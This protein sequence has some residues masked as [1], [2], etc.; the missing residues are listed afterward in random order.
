MSIITING[1][2]RLVYVTRITIQFSPE[3]RSGEQSEESHGEVKNRF[4][5]TLRTNVLQHLCC[6]TFSLVLAGATRVDEATAAST[7]PASIAKHSA[8]YRV[9]TLMASIQHFSPGLIIS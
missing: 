4:F 5:L 8:E 2:A 1:T 6:F 9:A 7:F 3:N